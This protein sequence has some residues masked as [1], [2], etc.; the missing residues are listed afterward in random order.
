MRCSW[1]ERLEILRLQMSG[2]GDLGELS[3]G[4][5]GKRG[6]PFQLNGNLPGISRRLKNRLPF[7][8]IGSRNR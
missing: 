2:N 7:A 8:E 6:V 3:R 1:N 4:A 5:A